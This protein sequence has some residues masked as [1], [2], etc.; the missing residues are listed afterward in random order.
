MLAEHQRLKEQIHS[1]NSQLEQLPNGKLICTR[2]ARHYKWYHSDGKKQTYIPKKNQH[3]AEQLAVKKYLSLLS[4]ELAH[5]KRAIEFYLKHHKEKDGQ[6]NQLLT[7]H[8][9]YQRLIS[10]YFKPLSKELSDWV[11]SPFDR[12]TKY[13]EQLTIKTVS[14]N[15][16]R[17]KSEALIDM[18]LHVNR[19]PFRYECALDLGNVIF[20]PDFTIRHPQTGKFY[21]WEHFGLMNDPA[22][23]KNAFSKQQHY[24][25]HDI[26]PSVQLI[27]TYESKENPL[28][29]EWVATLIQHYFL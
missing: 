24:A 3:F 20:Y 15:L 11:I 16:V 9:E 28:N 7:D 12:N 2:N 13:P 1:L 19:I 8:P 21:Y 26:L 23:C 14:G 22:Y 27:T 25:A 6:A 4:E 5:E 29:M 18:M 17:S 10:P